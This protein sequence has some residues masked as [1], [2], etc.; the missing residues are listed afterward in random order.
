[1]RRRVAAPLAVVAAIAAAAPWA[2][3]QV[4]TTPPPPLSAKLVECATGPDAVDRS[5]TFTG[6]MPPITQAQRM[7]MRFDLFQRAPGARRWSRVAVPKWSQWERSDPDRPG[8]IY[9]KHVEGLSGP[10][11]YRAVVTFRWYSARARLLRVARRTTR[12]CSQ[13][14]P[15]PDL[16][17]GVLTATQGP[18]PGT[19][20]YQLVVRNRGLGPAAPFDTTLTVAGQTPASERLSGLDAGAQQVIGFTAARCA[21]GSTVQV[22]LDARD[23]VDEADEADDAVTRACPFAS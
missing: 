7:W 9:T 19:A 22:V 13:P 3:A 12:A 16:H 18:Q 1:M 8:F 15:R 6:S 21:P 11:D 10:A 20:V 5:A 23:E 17:A 14:D 4:P 2:H